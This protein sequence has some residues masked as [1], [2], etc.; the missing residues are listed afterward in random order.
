M[1]L[2]FYVALNIGSVFTACVLAEVLTRRART[3][4]KAAGRRATAARD[5]ARAHRREVNNLATRVAQLE[6]HLKLAPAVVHQRDLGDGRGILG[7][8]VAFL[9]AG[10]SRHT[11]LDG[12]TDVKVTPPAELGDRFVLEFLSPGLELSVPTLI[13][14]TRNEYG[15]RSLLELA[16]LPM[17][18]VTS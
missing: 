11:T 10:I 12:D 15:L 7:P 16:G 14:E 4:A 3:I 18:P 6:H 2:S 13:T 17:R 5:E 9:R 8:I 1:D